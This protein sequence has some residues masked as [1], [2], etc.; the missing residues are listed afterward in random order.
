MLIQ[1]LLLECWLA[2][3]R[4]SAV[5]FASIRLTFYPNFFLKPTK[6]HFKLKVI[7]LKRQDMVVFSVS[8]CSFV[9]RPKLFFYFLDISSYQQ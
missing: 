1:R 7:G 6:E 3:F 8:P 9:I 2:V 4:D 5:P